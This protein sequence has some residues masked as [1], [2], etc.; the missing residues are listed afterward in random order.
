M[1]LGIT[2]PLAGLAAFLIAAS[3]ASIRLAQIAERELTALLEN[4]YMSNE[5]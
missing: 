5:Y 4:N 2:S 3:S 1:I